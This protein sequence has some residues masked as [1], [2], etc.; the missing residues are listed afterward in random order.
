MNAA[1]KM[2]WLENLVG[3]I[4]VIYPL[5]A[6]PQIIGIWMNKNAAIN[7]FFKNF[8]PII[9]TFQNSFDNIRARFFTFQY[10]IYVS[11]KSSRQEVFL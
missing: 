7:W 8:F 10:C 6:I 1:G 4:A 11:V 2:K 9:I 5:S 3:V